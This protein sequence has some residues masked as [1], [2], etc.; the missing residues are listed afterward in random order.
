MT[1]YL[2]SSAV[3]E[4]KAKDYGLKTSELDELRK[5]GWNTIGHLNS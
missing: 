3:F 1:N 4:D 5:R 2:T